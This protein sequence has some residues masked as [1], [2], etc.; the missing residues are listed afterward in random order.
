MA[1]E[2]EER[3]VV[4]HTK[5]SGKYREIVWDGPGD[6]KKSLLVKDYRF[7]YHLPQSNKPLNES[8]HAMSLCPRAQQ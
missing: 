8:L 7:I 3:A 1:S 5:D 6:D 4:A 2:F